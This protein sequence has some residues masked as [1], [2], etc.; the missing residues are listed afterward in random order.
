MIFVAW[1]F[2]ARAGREAEFVE[3]YAPSGAWARLFALSAGYQGTV[4]ARD[5]SDE[6]RYLLT[7][8]WTDRAAFEAFRASHGGEYEALD[9]HCEALTDEE[10]CLGWFET[11][12]SSP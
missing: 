1:E 6:R 5:T 4:L 11:V 8:A 12:E 9:R 10:R 7:D 2:R 3:H